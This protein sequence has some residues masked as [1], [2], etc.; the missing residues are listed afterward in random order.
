M[1]GRDDTR[2]HR[3]RP[4]RLA[5]AAIAVLVASVCAAGAAAALR[6]GHGTVVLM[7]SAGEKRLSVE[8]ATTRAQMERGLMYRR[9][10]AADAGMVF[11]FSSPVRVQFWMKNTLIPLSIAFFDRDGR[12]VRIYPMAACRR[13]PCP[14][15]DSM[16]RISGALEV[17]RGS[18]RRWGVRR[19]DHVTVH[20][21][22]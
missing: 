14:T 6:F 20:V 15:Y 9:R 5:I 17:R 10:L 3:R 2:C 1:R 16:Q 21:D 8:V 4:R 13:N 12:I 19:G 7:S 18:Y 22:S 11:L